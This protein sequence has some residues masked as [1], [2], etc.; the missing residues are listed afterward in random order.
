QYEYINQLSFENDCQTMQET[1][2]A[3][4]E[5]LELARLKLEEY[6]KNSKINKDDFNQ[7]KRDYTISQLQYW[8]FAKKKKQICDSDD[9]SILYFF[10]EDKACKDCNKQSFVL[11]YLKK[12]FGA[13]LLIFSI[14]SNFTE[15]PMVNLLQKSYNVTEFPTMMIDNQKVEGLHNKDE[16]M[17]MICPRYTTENEKCKDY[18]LSER[19]SSEEI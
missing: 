18:V 12:I 17:K 13:D 5:N 3:N 6:T 7:I 15:E 8:L 4:M 10:A 14:N 16:L 11:T 19:D 2:E 9:V 1:F